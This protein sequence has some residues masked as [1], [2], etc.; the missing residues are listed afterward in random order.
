MGISTIFLYEKEDTH[1]VSEGA[2]SNYYHYGVLKYVPSPI[3]YQKLSI[4]SSRYIFAGIRDILDL[5]TL[6]DWKGTGNFIK[7]KTTKRS[8]L[9]DIFNY[10]YIIYI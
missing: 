9:S 4:I 6:V 7:W 8:C 3:K 10:I 2:L 5:L 1:C